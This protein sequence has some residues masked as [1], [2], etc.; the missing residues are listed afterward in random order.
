MFHGALGITNFFVCTWHALNFISAIKL[1]AKSKTA[2]LNLFFVFFEQVRVVLGYFAVLWGRQSFCS[3]FVYPKFY[4]G[5]KIIDDFKDTRARL[6][7]Y[8]EGL[9]G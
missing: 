8:I 9:K 1:L 4:S 6:F 3:L 2:K 5:N 7:R